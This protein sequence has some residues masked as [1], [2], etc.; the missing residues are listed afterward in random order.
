VPVTSLL[1]LTLWHRVPLDSVIL[2][3]KDM[4]GPNELVAPILQQVIEPPDT[5]DIHRSFESLHDSTFIE[6]PNDQGKLTSMGRFVTAIGLDLDIGRFVGLGCQFGLT[7][8]CVAIAAML[9][10]PKSPWRIANPLI[11][12]EGERAKRA[13]LDEDEHTNHNLTNIT[14][15]PPPCSIKNAH[16]L[17]SL[18]AGAASEYNMIMSRSFMSKAYFDGGLY[19][20]PLSMV[21]L[22]L[23]FISECEACGTAA[24]DKK[25]G[26]EKEAA[27]KKTREEKRRKEEEEENEEES[28]EDTDS[29][30]EK[31]EARKLSRHA[32][33]VKN[34]V[35]LVRMNSCSSTYKSLRTRVATYL[36]TSNNTKKEKEKEKVNPDDLKLTWK[37]NVAPIDQI[38]PS[39]IKLLRVLM[40]WVFNENLLV[41]QSVRGK[42]GDT[43][44]YTRPK[45]DLMEGPILSEAQ[46][47][48]ER[49]EQPKLN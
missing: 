18:V 14:T 48:R 22:M 8:E 3:L 44:N 46:V 7:N 19:S 41:Q 43:V 38:H 24:E 25:W 45:V 34:C 12:T 35:A 40:F 28:E 13:S 26:L 49:S 33:C 10:Q 23:A 29:D 15:L 5:S 31:I 30:D 6:S 9:Q 2:A 27:K 32:W 4:L 20:E 1:V 39:K 36:N 16:N 37:K 11:H 17:A 42:R 47:S 21:N